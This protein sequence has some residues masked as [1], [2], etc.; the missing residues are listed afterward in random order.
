MTDLFRITGVLARE[1][2]GAWLNKNLPAVSTGASGNEKGG[3][4]P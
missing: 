3:C 1:A 2:S 4:H